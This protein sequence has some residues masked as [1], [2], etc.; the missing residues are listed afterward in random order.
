MVARFAPGGL[1]ELGFLGGDADGLEAGAAAEHGDLPV[2]VAVAVAPLRLDLGG[3]F[4]F[5]VL[6]GGEDA[7][8][9]PTVTEEPA[10]VA[11]GPQP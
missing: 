5:H 2:A 11:F 8:R 9:Q 7:G 6:V 1:E 3:A 4:L 10:R